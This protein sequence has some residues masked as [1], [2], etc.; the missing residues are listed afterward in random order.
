MLSFLT[1]PN[2]PSSAL[3]IEEDSIAA[4]SLDRSRGRFYIRRAATVDPGA[5]VVTPNFLGVNIADPVSFA[6]SIEEVT[7]A[8]GLNG[9]KRWS[10]ALP[11]NS[12]RT[13]I[14][15]LETVPSAKA[16]FE[17][18]LDWKAEQTFG[19]PA[20]EMRLSS[21]KI[22]PDRDGRARFFVSAVR[23]ETIDEFE[24]AFERYGWNAGL[25]L[26][27]VLSEATWLARPR[28]TR[29]AML[30]SSQDDGFTALLMRGDEPAV[31]RSVTCTEAEVDDEIYRLLMFYND[32]FGSDGD[33]SH[34]LVIGPDK[35]VEKTGD[36]ASDALGRPIGVIGADEVGLDLPD[37]G[38]NF[39]SIAA[40]AGLASL[41]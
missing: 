41:G 18:I 17:E 23:L 22:S 2:F 26:P 34:L 12:A 7:V 39:A 14:I 25:I 37:G 20:M 40:A 13:S 11:A 32:R 24:R 6:Q 35:M 5:G 16:E 29:D 8:A 38:F 21:R 27:R 9:Q 10:V 15:T 30:L 36:I 1:K 3:G 4:I 31:V 28:P 33:L 19:A